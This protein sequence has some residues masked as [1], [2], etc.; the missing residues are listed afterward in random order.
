[1]PLET[2]DPRAAISLERILPRLEAEYA[3]S[4]GAD[5]WVAFKTRLTANF[6]RLFELLVQLYG[7]QYDFFYQLGAA[8][9]RAAR[10]WLARPAELKQLDAAREANPG[11]FQSQEMIGG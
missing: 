2:Q 10:L 4:A 8:V 9:V 6:P 1:M 3:A 11:W 7:G 5:D